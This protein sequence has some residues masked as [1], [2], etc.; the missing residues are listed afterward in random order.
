MRRRQHS[1]TKSATELPEAFHSAGRVRDAGD[2]GRSVRPDGK[3][4]PAVRLALARP[5]PNTCTPNGRRSSNTRLSP[6]ILAMTR[7]FRGEARAQHLLATKGAPEA[8][9]DLCHLPAAE[10]RRDPGARS[11]A[12][13]NAACACSAWRAANG[14]GAHWP[15]SQHDFDFRFLG[16]LGFVDPPRPEVPAAIAECRAAGVR[17]HHADRR[18]SRHRARDRAPGRPERTRRGASPARRSMRWTMP[19]CASACSHVDLCA[20]LQP[21]Q[22]LRLVQ[23]LQRRRRRRGDDRRR[24]QRRAGA[25]G[26]RRRHRD[27]RARHRRGARGGRAGAAG[28]QLR[29]HRR[30]RSARAGASTTTSPRPRASCSPCTCRSSRWRWCRPCCTGR[31]C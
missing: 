10:P 19:R 15:Q 27:G 4:D 22:K 17:V 3:G 13:P 12:W 24:R 9:I 16:L 30:A 2:A 25:E 23:V 28:R 11:S 26:G 20:R 29:Q 5:A 31:C 1:A 21:E 7:V 8:V 6:D 14:R 18:P